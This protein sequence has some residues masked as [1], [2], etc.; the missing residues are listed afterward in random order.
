VTARFCTNK[1]SKN[2]QFNER[3]MDFQRL[4]S[5]INWKFD[6]AHKSGNVQR[7]KWKA[8]FCIELFTGHVNIRAGFVMQHQ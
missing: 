3:A 6:T 7:N 1:Q 2:K 4:C 8:D 5:A